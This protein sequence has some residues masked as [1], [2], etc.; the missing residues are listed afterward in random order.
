MLYVGIDSGRKGCVVALDPENSMAHWF[1][2]PYRDDSIIDFDFMD[3]TFKMFGD[4]APIFLEKV[5]G[6][7]GWA[8]KSTFGFGVNYGQIL[9]YLYNKPHVQIKP[10][11]WQKL[12]HFGVSGE[13]AKIKSKKAFVALN[14]SF[15][16]KMLPEYKRQGLIDAFH[17][18]RYSMFEY[19][20]VSNKHQF[21]FIEVLRPE[22]TLKEE[23][24]T[25][26]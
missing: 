13:E 26:S 14:P 12:A 17:I 6:R 24:K 9:G 5:M 7:G 10:H 16:L 18:A 25:E 15:D 11:V 2:L 1:M 22:N 23:D 19:H 4:I 21:K 8:A 3:R 20:G